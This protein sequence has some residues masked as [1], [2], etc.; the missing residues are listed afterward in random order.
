MYLC[1]QTG[2]V[3]QLQHAQVFQVPLLK[4]DFTG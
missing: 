2:E 4:T 3:K 1:L